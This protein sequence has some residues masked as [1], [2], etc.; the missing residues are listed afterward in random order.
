MRLWC[1][2]YYQKIHLKSVQTT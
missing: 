1:K 2:L